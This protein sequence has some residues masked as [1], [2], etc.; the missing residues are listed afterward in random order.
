MSKDFLTRGRLKDAD[1]HH[2]VFKVLPTPGIVLAV[3]FPVLTI[4]CANEAFEALV[5]VA[6]SN[7]I[8][9]GFFDVFSDKTGVDTSEWAGLFEKAVSSNVILKLPVVK[10]NKKSKDGEEMAKPVHLL[11]S[12]AHFA[13]LSQMVCSFADVTEV[14]SGPKYEKDI[15]TDR[16]TKLLEEAQRIAR[17]GSWEANLTT[18]TIIW[19]DVTKEIYGVGLDFTPSF[20][21]VIGFIKIENERQ[22]FISLVES[23]MENGNMFDLDLQI[24]TAAGNERTIRISGQAEYEDG[25]CYKIY[26]A[27]QDIT[28]KTQAEHFLK[29]SR[30]HLQSLV[31][32]VNGI[33]WE[34]DALAFEFSFVSD[35]V[36]DILGYSPEEW[37]EERNFWENHIHPDDVHNAVTY[38]QNQVGNH[39]DHTLDYRMIR[40]DGNVIWIK[41]IVSVIVENGRPTFLRG[42]ML[43]ITETK[44]LEELNLLEKAVL[45]LH[46]T[47]DATLRDLLIMYLKGIET[48]YP[49]MQCSMHEVKE[50]LLEL[51]FAP[52]ISS[53]YLKLLHKLSIGPDVGSCGTAAYLKQRV[54]VADIASDPKWSRYAEA[55]LKYNLLACWSQ[56]II[57]SEG[58]VIATLGFYYN[59]VKLPDE[60]ELSLLERCAAILRVILENRRKSILLEE[61][62]LLMKQGQGLAGFGN[63]QWDILNDIVQWS[64]ELYAIYG[65]DKTAFKATFDGYQELLHPDDRARVKDIILE[66]LHNKT[67]IVF[68]ERIVRPHGEIRYLK[69]WGRLQTDE[70]GAPVK[71]IGACLDITESRRYAKAIDQQNEKLQ[72][73]A[74]VQSHV[75]RAPLARLMGAVDLLKNYP[76]SEQE[77]KQFLDYILASAQELEGVIR[78]ISQKAS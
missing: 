31:Q 70:R 76:N 15:A 39:K 68:E 1:L 37:L 75:V 36:K 77:N 42:L 41:D 30:E 13:G 8:G 38:C 74:F 63:W 3:D 23:A 67:D 65:L 26:G 60:G 5:G 25:H 71:M 55:A 64:D 19:S 18:S 17:I 69:S 52:S 44:R 34:A 48:I 22:T 73:I 20:D 50:N 32:S 7:L 43:D 62:A 16:N 54:I 45:E 12:V 51:A 78:D 6:E 58:V 10:F 9:R 14:I 21:D 66:V 24:T 61:S 57:N 59:K 47:N 2:D 40:A 49:G 4:L 56:P 29:A 33:F 27:V 53:D 72:D 35:H 46:I 11:G 28:E